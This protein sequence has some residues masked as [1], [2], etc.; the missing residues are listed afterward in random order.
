MKNKMNPVAEIFWATDKQPGFQPSNSARI[1]FLPD[2][3]WYTY[4]IEFTTTD[5]LTLLRFDPGTSAGVAEV[6]WVELYDIEY[7]EVPKN[8]TPWVDPNWIK[9]VEK[10]HTGSSG[11][12]RIDLDVRGTGAV[13]FLNDEAVGEIYP[14]AYHNPILPLG[15]TKG[16]PFATEQTDTPS[17]GGPVVF[18]KTEVSTDDAM[19][20]AVFTAETRTRTERL[21]A[22]FVLE[23]GELSFNMG[24]SPTMFGP[25]CRPYGEMQQAI[26]SGVEYLE[27]GEHSSS[28]A[29]MEIKDHL[30]FVPSPM[31]MTMRFM[32]IVT[33]K[34]AF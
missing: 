17:A 13:I 18:E 30:R 10:W 21:L 19:G 8:P 24:T 16:I 5:P 31:D 6:A 33:D 28:T 34:I 20:R 3:E 2:G 27:K 9:K 22:Y 14:L 15:G 1:G 7:G 23:D 12:L 26:L 11:N 29:D 25:V 4:S 32:S